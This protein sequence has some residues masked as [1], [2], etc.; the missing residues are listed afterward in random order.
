MLTFRSILPESVSVAIL[1]DLGS[2][3]ELQKI[4][5]EEEARKATWEKERQE[6]SGG[7]AEATSQQQKQI[8]TS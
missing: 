7:V 5:E 4:R 8:E 3:L 6:R 1:M 2:H